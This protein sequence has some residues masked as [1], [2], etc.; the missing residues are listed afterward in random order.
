MNFTTRFSEIEQQLALIDPE[1]YA[2][3]RNYLSG[4]VTRLSPYISRGVISTRRVLQSLIAH[5]HEWEQS[6]K[7]VQE[8]AWRDYFQRVWEQ[9]ED[10][11]FDDIRHNRTG[12][13]HRQMPTA[14]LNA[15]T[16]IDAVDAGIRELY[17]TGYMHNHLRMYTASLA[18]NIGRAYWQMP[19]QWMYYHLLDGDIASNICSWQ[20]V[21]G[22]FSSKKYYCNQEN[23]NRYT[24]SDQRET[25]LD[26]EYDRLPRMAVPLELKETSSFAASTFLPQ[27]DK[28]DISGNLPVYLYN[29]YNLDPLWHAGK[30]GHR[31]LVLEPSHFRN[32][33]VG[34]KVVRFILQLAKNIEGIKLFV[35]EISE[36]PALWK[37]PAVYSKKHPAFTHYPG[38]KEERDW[39]V[40]E[41]DGY[42]PSFFAYWKKCSPLLKRQFQL[43]K[44][45]SSLVETV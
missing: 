38:V 32:H 11:I 41:L 20:W 5:G 12:V 24:G 43:Q 44:R 33:P 45:S 23:I 28:P 37:V 29:S 19:S 36:L 13:L 39:L 4:A 3:T 26:V 18:C 34:E 21:A 35:G 15:E 14:L 27:T 30:P 6:E 22:S 17:Q 9:L 1:E 10:D 7:L 2:R 40:P 31:L 42:F 16:G 8:L 25:Y